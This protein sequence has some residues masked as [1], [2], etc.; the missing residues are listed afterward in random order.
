MYGFS[1]E[2]H[3]DFTALR[4]GST[5]LGTHLLE[6]VR[7]DYAVLK[8]LRSERSYLWGLLNRDTR[9]FGGS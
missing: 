8:G 2:R 6:L 5:F 9:I 3:A 7:D 4:A 1:V